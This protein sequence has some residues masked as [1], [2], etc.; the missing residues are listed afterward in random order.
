MDG[1][2]LGPE[3]AAAGDV[4][5]QADLERITRRALKELGLANVDFTMTER[6]DRPG[7]WSVDIRG[8]SGPSQITIRCGAGTSPQFVREQIFQQMT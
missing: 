6:P 8:S 3:E 2:A 7:L 1:H 4:V 5:E